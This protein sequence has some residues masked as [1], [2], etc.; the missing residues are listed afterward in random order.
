MSTN[1]CIQEYIYVIKQY[2]WSEN[3]LMHSFV[4]PIIL[5]FPTCL[6]MLQQKTETI[7]SLLTELN[8]AT[9]DI[10]YEEYPMTIYLG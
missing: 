4:F 6:V 2:E 3:N 7:T 10:L 8:L 1:Y 5:L 9:Y